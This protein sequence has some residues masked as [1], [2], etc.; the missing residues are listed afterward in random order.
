MNSLDGALTNNE[1][2]ASGG[3]GDHR[4]QKPF[5]FILETERGLN[6]SIRA[7]PREGAGR[8][9]QLVSDLRGTGEE[10]GAWKRPPL[11]IPCL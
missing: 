2:T 1:Q 9:I 11:R 3:G 4:Q 10:A 7:V 8:T 6:L 5:T